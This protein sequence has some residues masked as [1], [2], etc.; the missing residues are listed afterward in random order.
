MPSD[1]FARKIIPVQNGDGD[2]VFPGHRLDKVLNRVVRFRSENVKK[3]IHNLK[4]N[5]NIGFF[6]HER[7]LCQAGMLEAIT[8]GNIRPMGE[9]LGIPGSLING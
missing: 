9:A 8:A 7:D 1:R 5:D 6:E 4:R 3:L 2:P